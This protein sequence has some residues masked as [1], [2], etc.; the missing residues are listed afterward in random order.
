MGHFVYML[1]CRDNSLYTGY[2]TN[3]EKR[4]KAHNSGKGAKYTRA[5][6]PVS[7]VFYREVEDRSTGLKLEYK[8]KKLTKAKKE[9]L[10]RDFNK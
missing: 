2:T 3:L 1:R 9:E 10:V 4:L 5:R 8:I 7:L 6:R